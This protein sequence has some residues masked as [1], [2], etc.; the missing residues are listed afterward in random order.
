M[1]ILQVNGFDY[2]QV[3]ICMNQSWML[4]M[5][6]HDTFKSNKPTFLY[7]FAIIVPSV[8]TITVYLK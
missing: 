5:N 1:A 2:V 7:Y 6:V 8:G 4:F 3:P